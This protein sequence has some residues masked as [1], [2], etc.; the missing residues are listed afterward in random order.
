[1]IKIININRKVRSEQT[2]S[3]DQPSGASG[4]TV[5][6]L[7]GANCNAVIATDGNYNK[8]HFTLTEAESDAF[9]ALA[10]QIEGRIIRDINDLQAGLEALQPTEDAPAPLTNAT[11]G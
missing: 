8:G 1:M 4:E 2:F 11:A 3:G 9:E 10:Q 7:T 6:R 5:L